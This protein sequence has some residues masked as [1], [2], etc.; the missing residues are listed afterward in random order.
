MFVEKI[1]I[2]EKEHRFELHYQLSSHHDNFSQSRTTSSNSTHT[3][4][5]T[6]PSTLS[7]Y[8]SMLSNSQS[9]SLTELSTPSHHHP[10]PDVMATGTSSRHTAN[11]FIQTMSTAVKIMVRH[12]S[13]SLPHPSLPF[14]QTKITVV[15]YS[16]SRHQIN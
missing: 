9:P 4:L 5:A 12:Y 8:G 2:L 6:P 15:Y 3:T 16:E 1:A 11:A 14:R 10:S 7:S 13:L